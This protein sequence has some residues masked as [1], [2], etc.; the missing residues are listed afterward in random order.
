MEFSNISSY[1]PYTY[2]SVSVNLLQC[3][4]YIRLLESPQVFI[5]TT[6]STGFPLPKKEIAFI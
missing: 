1:N 4:A 5:T 3:I 2:V 6:K